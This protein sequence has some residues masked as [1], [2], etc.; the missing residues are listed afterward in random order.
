MKGFVTKASVVAM[1]LYSGN[2]E[3]LRVEHKHRPNR[4]ELVHIMNKKFSDLEQRV[5]QE[6]Q[7]VEGLEKKLQN[8]KIELETDQTMLQRH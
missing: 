3:Q 4:H 8:A 7:V 6:S 2:A 1:L 5:A